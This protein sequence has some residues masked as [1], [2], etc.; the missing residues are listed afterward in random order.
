MTLAKGPRAVHRSPEYGAAPVRGLAL[1]YAVV[2][3]NFYDQLAFLPLL[4]PRAEALGATAF[5]VG[6]IV[7]IYSLTSA[8]GN[9]VAGPLLDRLGRWPFIAG[10]F[11]LMA[12]T[13]ALHAV[14]ERPDT[15]L[16]L[17]AAHGLAGG[18]LMPAAFALLGDAGAR[19]A[20]GRQMGAAGGA[21]ALAAVIAPP[22]SGGLADRFGFGGAAVAVALLLL[23]GAVI[24]AVGLPGLER[25]SRSHAPAPVASAEAGPPAWRL[26]AA[27]YAAAFVLM[28]GQGILY[29]A[30][31]L[32]ATAEGLTGASTGALFTAFAVGS[33]IAFLTPLA[34]LGDRIGRSPAVAAGLAIVGASHLALAVAA[35]LSVMIGAMLSLGLGFGL[36]FTSLGAWI[37]ELTTPSH[38]GRAFGFFYAI[39]SGG[40][41]AGALAAGLLAPL[42]SPFYAAAAAVALAL[43]FRAARANRGQRS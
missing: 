23:A 4:S 21:I 36:V 1:V 11:A 6:A 18:A 34:R 43:A 3:I 31:P 20:R 33:L 16:A 29:Y 28:F 7:A 35:S 25:R 15:L 2:W 19:R 17:R 10:S 26:L 8:V 5:G 37:V 30:L 24:A 22:V 42:G 9:G 12:V 13:A 38:R 32:R 39:F 40:A 27:P 41:I 14:V